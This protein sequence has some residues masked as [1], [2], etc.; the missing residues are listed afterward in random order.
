MS[1][2]TLNTKLNQTVTLFPLRLEIKEV[3]GRKTLAKQSFDRNIDPRSGE[4]SWE[5]KIEYEDVVFNQKEFWIRWYPDHIEGLVPAKK[6]TP[7]EE[8]TFKKVLTTFEKQEQILDSADPPSIKETNEQFIT[9][10]ASGNKDFADRMLK[11]FN[12]FRPGKLPEELHKA[13]KEYNQQALSNILLSYDKNPENVGVRLGWGIYDLEHP[14]LNKVWREFVEEVG[15]VRARYIASH[16]ENRSY[17]TD[18][19]E[20]EDPLKTILNQGVKITMLPPWLR[21]STLHKTSDDDYEIKDLA[22]IAIPEH[23]Q[24]FISKEDIPQAR[25]MTDFP[26]ALKKGMGT[27]ISDPVLVKQIEDADWLIA[28]GV[29]E[30]GR[31]KGLTGFEKILRGLRSMGEVTIVPQDSP[32]NNTDAANS[33]FSALET[34]FDSYFRKTR[35]KIDYVPNDQGYHL[36]PEFFESFN[37]R[38][39]RGVIDTQLLSAA[40]R[41]DPHVLSE[42]PYAGLKEQ[43]EAGAMAQLLWSC[44]LGELKDYWSREFE[45]DKDHYF[46]VELEKFFVNYVRAAG[47][48]PV[49]K[50]GDNP[51]GILPVTLMEEWPT[52]PA[53]GGVPEGTKDWDKVVNLLALFTQLLKDDFK[54]LSEKAPTLNR[55]DLPDKYNRLLEVLRR[56]R[57]SRRVYAKGYATHPQLTSDSHYVVCPLVKDLPEDGVED[58]QKSGL[59][60]LEYIANWNRDEDGDLDTDK[61][62]DKIALLDGV[63]SEKQYSRF[64]LLH[65]II[66]YYVDFLDSSEEEII[67]RIESIQPFA[68]ALV[69]LHPDRLEILMTEVLDLLSYRLDAWITALTTLKLNQCNPDNLFPTPGVYGWIEKPGQKSSGD[70][71][72]EYIQAPSMLQ[73]AGAAIVANASKNSA[74]HDEESPFHLN[75][76]SEQVRKGLW[77]L[78]SLRQGH[79]SG[80]VLGYRLERMIQEEAKRLREEDPSL[81]TAN[82]IQEVDI[83]LLRD[84]YRLRRNR[85]GIGDDGE[86]PATPAVVDGAAFLD[87]AESDRFEGLE[88]TV[89][90]DPAIKSGNYESIVT[91][92][93]QYRDAGSDIAVYEMMMNYMVGKVPAA[94]AWMDFLDGDCL[95]PE[96]LFVQTQRTGKPQAS[97]IILSLPA[98]N[99]LPT[100]GDP[101]LKIADP[102]L[103]DFAN[104]LTPDWEGE[105]ALLRFKRKDK[106]ETIEIN[107]RLQDDLQMEPLDLVLGGEQEL[108]QRVRYFI[109]DYWKRNE[110]EEL[111]DFPLFGETDELLNE[112]EIEWTSPA[113]NKLEFPETYP[114]EY[115]NQAKTL[116]KVLQKNRTQEKPKSPDPSTATLEKGQSYDKPLTYDLTQEPYLSSITDFDP[117]KIDWPGIY[118][119]L[120]E[121]QEIL[122]QKISDLI[123]EDASGGELGNLLAL[124]DADLVLAFSN[125]YTPDS[126]SLTLNAFGFPRNLSVM[127]APSHDGADD[128]PAFAELIR[129]R[130]KETIQTLAKRQESL[131]KI[132]D[133]QSKPE[134]D[135]REK[136]NL[137]VRFLGIAIDKPGFPLVLPIKH[138]DAEGWRLNFGN[139]ISDITSS[140]SQYPLELYET[141]KPNVKDANKLFF[142]RNKFE[143][144][145]RS[146]PDENLDELYY[147]SQPS[148][149]GESWIALL[150][151]DQFDEGIPSKI[152]T[153]GVSLYFPTSKTQAPNAILI[154]VPPKITADGNWEISKLNQILKTT[155]DL[156]KIRMTTAEDVYGDNNLGRY[157]PFWLFRTKP[158]LIP[159]ATRTLADTFSEHLYHYILADSSEIHPSE[160]E[161]P[162]VMAQRKLPPKL[163]EN[164]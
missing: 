116:L 63:I 32:T 57:V 118:D 110:I 81:A 86:E 134:I 117:E 164:L 8:D 12:G 143:L 98:S 163:G 102:I 101:I 129:T 59:E 103:F 76:S 156:M 51:Y 9:D 99:P 73:A 74:S 82:G 29:D 152:E 161:E 119:V 14:G 7:I 4:I 24:L 26:E 35:M 124:A 30:T 100:E 72:S 135:L 115:L 49:L 65:R 158:E 84:K 68:K 70:P 16:Y 95:P 132:K 160:R 93:K 147:S 56:E 37:H 137:A 25:W 60:Y 109:L 128:A 106:E 85:D 75:L 71:S 144:Y 162:E 78:Q 157:F 17:S 138:K 97:K 148:I 139:P 120:H 69:K 48:L 43:T 150:P 104:Q 130:L 83:Y 1:R 53:V 114:G 46:W 19:V 34:D 20:T 123:G 21:L 58:D 121:R 6:I 108:V 67:Q 36:A 105:K 122:S 153:T 11:I 55:G 92:L 52:F 145:L 155:I 2:E 18:D 27:I 28:L 141:I 149:D 91:R 23:D 64:S 50:I 87:A 22:K 41:I 133:K 62:K 125:P 66:A 54:F 94:T 154:A 79:L 77:Y 3:S 112:I 38:M 136:I 80:E 126:L 151:I 44:G 10:H 42:I 61:L 47:P 90:Y 39:D 89:A 142:K 131:L 127:P 15:V 5:S 159:A 113:G 140:S 146:I 13:C 45:I 96:V 88:S 107:F 33:P 111:G 31:E 40:L